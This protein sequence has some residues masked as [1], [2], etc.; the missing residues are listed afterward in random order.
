[1][2]TGRRSP[3]VAPA[4]RRSRFN[5]IVAATSPTARRHG[6]A[7]FQ[8]FCG[9]RGAPCETRP[10]KGRLLTCRPANCRLRAS[11][12]SAPMRLR[13]RHRFQC[14]Y[15]RRLRPNTA[16]ISGC[17][18]QPR[19]AIVRPATTSQSLLGCQVKPRSS[20]A[21]KNRLRPGYFDFGL[22]HHRNV[23]VCP[24]PAVSFHHLR[25]LSY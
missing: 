12:R 4:A 23:A 16:P 25:R 22:L 7:S 1:M 6:P 14:Q 9:A 15:P 11:S 8:V 20:S 5:D 18:L 17:A 13:A 24:I 3:Q 10:D 2:C 19:S 21:I